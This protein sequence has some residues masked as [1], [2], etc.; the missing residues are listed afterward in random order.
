MKTRQP[1][2]FTGLRKEVDRWP[3][4][5]QVP[6][7]QPKTFSPDLLTFQY[8]EASSLQTM[9]ANY[10]CH[11]DK[12]SLSQCVSRCSLGTTCIR[13]PWQVFKN[14]ESWA[15]GMTGPNGNG[16]GPGFHIFSEFPRILYAQVWT[17]LYQGLLLQ[18]TRVNFTKFLYWF[19]LVKV[20]YSNMKACPQIPC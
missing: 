17:S 1:K 12:H 15:S 20:I 5:F 14:R 4:T 2:L 3:L 7:S 16:W 6:P 18:I 11:V 19:P 10:L 9:A 13:I 8:P